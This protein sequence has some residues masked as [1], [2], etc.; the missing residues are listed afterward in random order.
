MLLYLQFY[1][2]FAGIFIIKMLGK[3]LYMSTVR[4]PIWW[5]D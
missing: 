1:K 5:R 3:F 2:Y 4:Q